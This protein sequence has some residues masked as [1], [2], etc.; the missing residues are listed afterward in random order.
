MTKEWYEEDVF[1]NIP[2]IPIVGG[3]MDGKVFIVDPSLFPKN[4]SHAIPDDDGNTC[5]YEY[6]KVKSIKEDFGPSSFNR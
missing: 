2:K 6:D 4:H 3:P 5:Y 1:A